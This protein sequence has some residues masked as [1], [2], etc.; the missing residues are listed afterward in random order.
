M[1]LEVR[2]GASSA[3]RVLMVCQ[4]GGKFQLVALYLVNARVVIST[5]QVAIPTRQISPRISTMWLFK[6][7]RLSSRSQQPP[8]GRHSPRICRQWVINCTYSIQV[9]NSR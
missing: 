3:I 4:L 5:L 1:V 9:H 8:E 2:S 7:S 6:I